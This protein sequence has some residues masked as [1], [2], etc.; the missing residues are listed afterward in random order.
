MV[1]WRRKWQHIPVFLPGKPHEQ[2]EET[3]VHG[4]QKV[5]HNLATAQQSEYNIQFFKK[6]FP[7]AFIEVQWKYL[8]YW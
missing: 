2:C 6:A 1:H 7:V 5:G 4:S 3:A 8:D